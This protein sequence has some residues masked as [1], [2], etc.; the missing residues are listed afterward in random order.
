MMDLQIT[1]CA[2]AWVSVIVLSMVI[3]NAQWNNQKEM[4][5]EAKRAQ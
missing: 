3:I 4:E 1:F 5:V 2:G